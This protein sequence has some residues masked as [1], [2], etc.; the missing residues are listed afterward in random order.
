MLE[1]Y[2]IR[3]LDV[4]PKKKFWI[5]IPTPPKRFSA[6]WPTTR[7]PPA[8]LLSGTTEPRYAAWS[9]SWFHSRA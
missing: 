5:D 6:V 4:A 2:G 7:N 1:P 8:T 9:F 3:E